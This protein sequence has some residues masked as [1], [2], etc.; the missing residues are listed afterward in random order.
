MEKIY[1]SETDIENTIN[2]DRFRNQR[3]FKK[4]LVKNLVS[5]IDETDK[6]GALMHFK[7]ESHLK[8]YT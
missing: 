4:L 5:Q 3:R 2:F 1:K 7:S 6:R 8:T